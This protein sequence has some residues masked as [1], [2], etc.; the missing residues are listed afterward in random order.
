MQKSG[1]R[2]GTI[3]S[4]LVLL[5]GVAAPGVAAPGTDTPAGEPGR[6]AAAAPGQAPVRVTLIT[7]DQVTAA[8]NKLTVRPGAGREGMTFQSR[9]V[10]GHVHV[11]PRDAEAL[12][13]AG[14]LDARLF[15]VT[16]LAEYG[17]GDAERDDLPLLLTYA[18][19]ISARSAADGV[20]ITRQLPAIDGAAGVVD[21]DEATEV[22]NQITGQAGARA[23]AGVPER[24][25]LDGRR[26]VT[27]DHSV[28]QIGAPA[29]W[30]AGL[31]GKG[32]TVAVL[33][34]GVD[35]T[36]PDLAGTV[37]EARNFSET[38]EATRHGRP[39]HPR[40][41][42]HRR[43]RR[44]LRRQVPGRRA[45]RHAAQTARSAR[46]DGCTDSAILAGMQW[47]A[48][49]QQRRGGQHEPRRRPTPRRSTRWRRRCKP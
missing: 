25:W 40:R 8:G 22:W 2:W 24:I 36:H 13:R 39:R 15:D 7:G 3:G 37:A 18:N 31:T 45:G 5:L 23:A 29:A 32:V 20:T 11:V 48:V 1:K 41:L 35:A 27:L 47:A 14:R 38:P 17:Y 9:R 6:V 19:G 30:E 34:T 43:Q 49:E 16:T 10:G 4:A 44:R 21:K 28:P 46:S 12:I 26:K 33:D 42:D